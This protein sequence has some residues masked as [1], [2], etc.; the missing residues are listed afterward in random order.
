MEFDFDKI[1]RLKEIR[2]EKSAL[3]EKETSLSEP[4]LRD[5]CMICGLYNLFK[6]ALNEKG[7]PPRAESVTQRKKFIFIVLYLYAPS[8]LAG[9]KMP[10]GLR[11]EICKALNFHSVSTISD[12][13]SDIVFLYQNYSNFSS[14]VKD[15]FEYIMS[16]LDVKAH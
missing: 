12:N 9:G 15:I 3:S 14:D 13:C 10:K 1:I 4:I 8:V 7:C 11:E 6:D 5:R 16:R 2:I